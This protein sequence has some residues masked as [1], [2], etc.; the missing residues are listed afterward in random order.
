MGG[1]VGVWGREGRE[2]LEIRRWAALGRTQLQ[3][4]GELDLDTGLELQS[5]VEA[6]LDD[7]WD[8]EIDLAGV[9]F[10][11]CSGLHLLDDLRDQAQARALAVEVTAASAQVRRTA[12]VFA[13]VGN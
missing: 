9:T 7:G 11:D 3:L 2:R 1:S 10:I 4:A 8:V 12:A 5:S 6:L 13:R